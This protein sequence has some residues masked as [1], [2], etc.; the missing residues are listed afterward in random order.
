[1][2]Q[3]KAGG[4]LTVAELGIHVLSI[5]L[6][7]I[8]ILPR[9]SPNA[10]L[11]FSEKNESL[12]GAARYRTTFENPGQEPLVDFNANWTVER[13]TVVLRA[14]TR[15]PKYDAASPAP[16]LRVFH[17]MEPIPALKE[18]D[19][20][21][22]CNDSFQINNHSFSAKITLVRPTDIVSEQ[23]EIY[24]DKLWE[25]QHRILYVRIS[26]AA[27][28]LLAWM[29]LVHFLFIKLRPAQKEVP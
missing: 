21:L 27:L 1:M 15:A 6:L 28:V 23:V 13:P 14:D 16:L 11:V 20:F 4:F 25:R 26:I 9:F 2:S 12:P 19:T 18:F 3:S 29:L 5:I 8:E 22:D 24:D 10:A 17:A 7:L